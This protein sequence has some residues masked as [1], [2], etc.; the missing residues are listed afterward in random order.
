M[1]SSTSPTVGQTVQFSTETMDVGGDYNP[2]TS[3][4]TA[5][6]AGIYSFTWTIRMQYSNGDY[7]TALMV[8]NA[9][10]DVLMTD[11]RLQDGSTYV[12]I[13]VSSTTTVTPLNVGDRVYIKVLYRSGS[14]IIFSNTGGHSTFSGWMI[15]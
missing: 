9:M 8:N 12:T 1:A 6:Q 13:Q 11:S 3:V 5:P 14:P 10:K 2:T 15:Q 7:E 4:F